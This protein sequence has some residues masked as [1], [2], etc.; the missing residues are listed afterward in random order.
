MISVNVGSLVNECCRQF[1]AFI[2]IL[3][4]Y[5]T[6]PKSRRLKPLSS[7]FFSRLLTLNGNPV[8]LKYPWISYIFRKIYL[9][10]VSLWVKNWPNWLQPLISK[11]CSLGRKNQVKIRH[12]IFNQYKSWLVYFDYVF[13]EKKS[14]KT[15]NCI[16]PKKVTPK[17]KKN[18]HCECNILTYVWCLY[19]HKW[20]LKGSI[21]KHNMKNAPH[22]VIFSLHRGL[23]YEGLSH[24]KQGRK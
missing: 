23:C 11:L 21:L 24:T 4:L 15:K 20:H 14:H 10:L 22:K 3:L 13:R 17:G 8:W 7:Q 2:D 1:Q 18:K 6:S 19:T 16:R 5:P 9:K 12:I